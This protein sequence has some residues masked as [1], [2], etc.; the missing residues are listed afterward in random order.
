MLRVQASTGMRSGELCGMR[1]EEIEHRADGVLLYRPDKHKTKH[2]GKPKVIPRL[3][4]AA[5]AVKPF[6]NREPSA[7]GFSPK[8]SVAWYREQRTAKRKTPLSCG[9]RVGDK[10]NAS[11]KRSP[12]DCYDSDSYRRAVQRAA[13]KAGVESWHPHQLRHTAASVI[14]EA[15]GIEYAT[16]MLGHSSTAMTAPYAKLTELKAI[17]AALA[18]PSIG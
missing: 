1:P 13:E 12:R 2:L 5:E 3:G 14:R 17:E 18:A 10:C 6:L 4:D 16:A 11:P 7:F 8:E 15:L 9:T